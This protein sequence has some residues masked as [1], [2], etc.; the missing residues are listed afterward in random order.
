M[1][2]TLAWGSNKYIS[3]VGLGCSRI[4][5]FSNSLSHSELQRLLGAAFDAGVTVFDTSDVYGQG[6]SE[7]EIGRFMTGPRRDQAIVVTKGGKLFSNKMRLLRPF[8]PLL[9]PLLSR[10]GR[11]AVTEKRSDEISEDFSPAHIAR[12]VDGS[13]SRLRTDRLDGFLLHSPKSMA[14]QPEL[15]EM[16]RRLRDSGKIDRYG[17]SCDTRDV[18]EASL[19]NPEVA[20]LELPFDV[21]ASIEGTSIAEEIVKRNIFV[22]AREVLRFQ[23]GV[24]P[25]KAVAKAASM[26]CVSSVIVGTT[27]VD[28]LRETI[29][30]VG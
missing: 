24:A 29:S 11:K 28:H 8:K 2:K 5:S 20:L 27:N 14:L 16:L 6:D 10:R 3:P 19:R 18:L 15:W 26:P 22:L 12:S 17:V 13:L 9:K 30:S 7:R 25:G 21:L 1:K 4:G 23:P